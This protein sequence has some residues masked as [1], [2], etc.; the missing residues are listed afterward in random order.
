MTVLSDDAVKRLMIATTSASVGNEIASAINTCNDLPTQGA[1]QIVDC[2]TGTTAD[3]TTDFGGLEVGDKILIL[4]AAAGNMQYVT[5]Q[6]SYSTGTVTYSNPSGAQVIHVGAAGAARDVSFTTQLGRGSTYAAI[7]AGGAGDYTLT[8]GGEDVVVAWNA[9]EDTTMQD[10]VTA[11]NLDAGVATLVP[12]VTASWNGTTH[13]I[14]LLTDD[15]Y[16]EVTPHAASF[17]GTGASVGA[18]TLAAS[19]DDTLTAAKAAA[20]ITADADVNIL[21][22]ADSALGVVTLTSL[23]QGSAGEHA[24]SVTGTGATRS[25]ATL[26][27]GALGGELPITGVVGSKYIVLRQVALPAASSAKF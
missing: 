20:M 6:E 13:Q 3:Q 7:V 26:D 10:I 4:P 17:T 25:A 18:V 5:C 24:L 12:T 9:D 11:F 19:G 21:V 16:E 15:P 8:V 1:W 23:T 2:F 27:G 22:S 14:D